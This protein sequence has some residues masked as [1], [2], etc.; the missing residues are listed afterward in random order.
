[1]TKLQQWLAGGIMFLALWLVLI[2]N[3][4]PGNV[5]ILCLLFEIVY[6]VSL[7]VLHALFRCSSSYYVAN[8][9]RRHYTQGWVIFMSYLIY[10]NTNLHIEDAKLDLI[11][12]ISISL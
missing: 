4:T 9:N 12:A 3:L 7:G 1:M 5:F 2:H 8:R 6:N 11:Y 10:T